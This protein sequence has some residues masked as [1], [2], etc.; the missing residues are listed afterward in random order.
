MTLTAM[1]RFGLSLVCAL[2]MTSGTAQTTTGA[3]SSRLPGDEVVLSI[4]SVSSGTSPPSDAY[5]EGFVAAYGPAIT[6]YE[7]VSI[8]SRNILSA[9]IAA[10]VLNFGGINRTY[11]VSSRKEYPT[12][13]F[14]TGHLPDDESSRLHLRFRANG[15]VEGSLTNVGVSVWYITPTLQMPYHLAY[16]RS[17]RDTPIN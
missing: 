16:Q 8:D 5:V 1:Y 11:I 3:L 7:L 6:Q 17:L 2:F 12:Q 15:E 13:L 9:E 14:W 10:I 4:E